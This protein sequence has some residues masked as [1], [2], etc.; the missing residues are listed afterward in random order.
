MDI[1]SYVLEKA[2]KAKAASRVIGSMKTDAKN[3]ALRKMADALEE[4]RDHLIRENLKDLKAGRQAGLSSAIL[5]RLELNEPRIRQMAL[6][7]REIASLPD[8]VGEIL[9]IRQRPNGMSVGRMRVPIGVIGFIF[10][11]RPNVTADSAALCLKAGNAVIL[12]GGS[13]A[14]NSNKAIIAI[15]KEAANSQGF[16]A[17]AIGFI[18]ITDRQAVMELLKLD[19]YV[20][21]IIPRGGEGLI[22][23]VTENSK[24]PV[25]RHYKGVCHVYVDAK[26]DMDMAGDIC[27]NSKVQRPGTCNAMESMLVD[28]AVAAEFLPI[29]LRRF[30]DAGVTVKGCDKTREFDPSVE[31]ASAG[32]YH[33]EYL[34]MVVNCRVVDGIEGAMEH[35][36]EFG[37]LH[38]ETIVTE[39]Y[40][41]AMRFVREVDASAV[42]VNVSTRF[43]DG[44]E[45]GLGAEIGIATTKLHARGPMGLE[46]LTS[47]K[48]IVFGQGQIR[49]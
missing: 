43:N 4:S 30:A 45:F 6:G 22:R 35:I 15:L 25:L 33:K 24:I 31:S 34:D 37:S 17:D 27:F 7:L 12:K 36:A 5:D 42:M 9:K 28:Q 18:D 47:V 19:D 2:A 32:D 41:S 16:P 21:V 40:A 29:M 11:S 38:T 1:K 3:L 20:D 14:I 48:F 49:L 44:F 23:A 26:A 39:S 46:E 8:P 13:E 10:E